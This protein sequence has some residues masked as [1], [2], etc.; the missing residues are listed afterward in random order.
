MQVTQRVEGVIITIAEGGTVI[1][2][3]RPLG[4]DDAQRIIS[5]A[6]SKVVNEG[7]RTLVIFLSK[8]NY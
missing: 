2:E 6:K 3:G 8:K 1:A 4:N 5:E 7:L